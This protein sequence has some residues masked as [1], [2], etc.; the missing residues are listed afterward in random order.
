MKRTRILQ[1]IIALSAFVAV[2]LF[3]STVFAKTTRVTFTNGMEVIFK[4]NHSS[5]MITSVVF[6]RAGAKYETD[7][8]NGVTHLL[9]HL[10]FDGTKTRSREEISDGIENHGGYI[11]AFTRKDM[12][13]FLVLMP[14]EYIEYG[15]NIQADQLFNSI[16]PDEELPKERKVVIEEIR[17]SDDNEATRAEYFFNAKSM[18]GTPYERPVLGYKNIISTI[19]KDEII[20]YWKQFYAPNNMIA[21]VIGDFETENMVALFRE[22]F[23]IIPPVESPSPPPVNYFPPKGKTVFTKGADTRQTYVSMAIDAPHFTDPEYYVFDIL[24]DYLSDDESSPFASV[25]V[26]SAGNKLYNSFSS[27]LETEEEYSRLVIEATTSDEQTARLI[28]AGVDSVLSEFS[29][30]APTTER[31]DAIKTSKKTQEI[32]MSEKLHYYGFIVAPILVTAGWDFVEGYLKNIDL[33]TAE[34]VR[35]AARERFD[36]LKYVAT[37]YHPRKTGSPAAEEKSTTAYRREVLENGLTLVVKSNPDSRVFALN[38]IGKNRSLMEPEG[39]TGITD[40]VNRMIKKGTTS[41]TGEELSQKLNEIGANV[42]LYD[43]PWIPYDDRYTVR[44]YSFMKFETIDEFADKGLALFADMIRHPAFDSENTENVR[45]SLLGIIA[46][47][48]NSTRDLAGDLFYRA[49]FAGHPYAKSVYGTPQTIAAITRDD[50]IKHH[51]RFYAPENMI[52]TVGTNAPADS[53]MAKLN[54]AFADMPRVTSTLPDL[55]DPHKQVGVIPVDGELEKDQ[56]QIIIGELLPG[57]NTEDAP[58]LEVAAEILSTRMNKTLRETQGLAYSV[59]AGA[60]LDRNFG[61][62]ICSMG[63]GSDNYDTA[64]EGMLAEIEKLKN[65]APSEEEVEI[66]KNSI[67]G[68]QLT[69]QLSRINQAYYMGV[70]EYLGLG[71]DY[72]D[73]FVSAIRNV[74]V[75]D[76]H[77]AANR[78]FD[79]DNYIIATAGKK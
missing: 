37:I 26:D 30:Y 69:R 70:Y 74:T 11:N 45:Q 9:E 55:P 56:V 33:V 65:E 34:M 66:A 59:G 31:L 43:N 46:R 48:S 51:K 54:D 53:V 29:S 6:V 16:F 52:I 12:T 10:L 13:G 63:T 32:Y 8:N 28:I 25:L 3:S 49:L 40:F 27:Y 71:Y 5:P 7:Y 44:E 47:R 60:H 15:L 58:A 50:L 39:K 4:E 41:Y 35:H 1:T 57:A 22:I 72:N 36:D 62:L 23:G 76:V 17:R 73:K 18:A 75:S 64:R 68:S 24:A 14:K 21:L 79:T 67:W 20:R 77:N 78:Y 19:T 61:W 2:V 38:V 42:T